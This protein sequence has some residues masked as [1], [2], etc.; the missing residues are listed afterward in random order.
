MDRREHDFGPYVGD[1][2]G[3]RIFLYEQGQPVH[4]DKAVKAIGINNHDE[5]K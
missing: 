1:R 3:Q 4:M 2:S 5:K